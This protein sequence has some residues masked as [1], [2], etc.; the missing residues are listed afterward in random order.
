MNANSRVTEHLDGIQNK[1]DELNQDRSRVLEWQAFCI[2]HFPGVLAV[3]KELTGINRELEAGL[4][5]A[6][7]A[8]KEV[9]RLV[10]EGRE[11]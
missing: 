5:Q 4:R 8:L 2:M 10:K 3:A 6:L 9:E 1:F 7:D 11:G